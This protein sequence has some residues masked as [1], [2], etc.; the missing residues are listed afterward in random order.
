MPSARPFGHKVIVYC[1]VMTNGIVV[2]CFP[3]ARFEIDQIKCAQRVHKLEQDQTRTN[4]IWKTKRCL[5][6]L[7]TQGATLTA[8]IIRA[9]PYNG[10][11][12]VISSGNM[13]ARDRAAAL[14][15][16]LCRRNSPQY[17][18]ASSNQRQNYNTNK[19][20]K[21]CSEAMQWF[22]RIIP[23]SGGD[24]SICYFSIASENFVSLE[25][26]KTSGHQG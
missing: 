9:P 2:S 11:S 14:S 21:G 3:R 17:R 19:L 20:H 5:V 7:S 10:D 24:K 12:A 13:R 16:M 15:S 22:Y 23:F 4:W 25:V 6:R 26:V 8:L 1:Q 18:D